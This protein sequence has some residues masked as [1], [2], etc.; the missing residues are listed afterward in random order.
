MVG[1]GTIR[2]FWCCI[3]FYSILFYFKFGNYDFLMSSYRT[4]EKNCDF[5]S[6]RSVS[7]SGWI[8]YRWDTHRHRG[9]STLNVTLLVY[10]VF[11]ARSS[12]NFPDADDYGREESNPVHS[13]YIPMMNSFL[14]NE[15]TRSRFA[16]S[17]W[18]KRTSYIITIQ[19]LSG[20]SLI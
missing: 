15:S 2:S 13:F 1:D 9:E 16:L 19:F 11:A 14:K 6:F 5:Y 7:L 3:L 12:S 8:R 20:Q 10:T 4:V 17:K 18:A